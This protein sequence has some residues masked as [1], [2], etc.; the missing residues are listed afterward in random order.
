MSR[1]AIT[2]A[3]GVVGRVLTEQLGGVHDIIPI[4][5]P[6]IDILADPDKLKRV[7]EAA[8]VVIHLA[9]VFGPKAEGK[10]NWL[11]PHQDPINTRLFG[12][13]MNMATTLAENHEQGPKQFIHASSIH[14]E[15]TLGFL[16]RNSGLLVAKPNEFMTEPASGYG[17]SKRAQEIAVRHLAPVFTRGAVSVRLGGV[18]S[19][20]LPLQQHRRPEV[21]DHEQRVWLEHS[22]LGRLVENLIEQ[23]R[24]GQYDVLYAISANDGRFH[25]TANN[26]TWQPQANSK[27]Y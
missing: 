24:V 19:D 15:D 12:M 18:T 20:N 27:D 26:F 9:G 6:E 10:E 14:V 1:I 16:G 7:L 2:G 23:P 13:V 4:D 5:L 3:K 25:D 17:R 8:D 22:D 11:S 21:L